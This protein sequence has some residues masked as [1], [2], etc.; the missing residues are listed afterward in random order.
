M[1]IDIT[2]LFVFILITVLTGALIDKDLPFKD[3]LIIDNAELTSYQCKVDNSLSTDEFVILSGSFNWGENLSNILCKSQ[4]F[5]KQFGKV[6][7]KWGYSNNDPF[8][9]NSDMVFMN[10]QQMIDFND[11]KKHSYIKVAEYSSYK[12]FFIGRKEI[13]QLT[14]SY[15][16]NKRIGL[17]SKK[18][19][20][21]GFILPNKK[22]EEMGLNI[23]ELNIV[24]ASSHSHLRELIKKGDVDIIASYFNEDDSSWSEEA[25]AVQIGFSIPFE[26]SGTG[27][28]IKSSTDNQ[29]LNCMVVKTLRKWSTTL[30]NKYFENIHI[31]DICT[32]GNGNENIV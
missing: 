1:K 12:S 13:P 21:S 28:Y 9:Y 25:Y 11:K 8:D 15:F 16:L 18:T 23:E 3:N 17:L 26:I 2:I 4:R 31:L 24:Y 14:K 22:L 10:Q 7:A 30:T 20:R 27:W 19:S 29:P 5:S 32:E 6:T